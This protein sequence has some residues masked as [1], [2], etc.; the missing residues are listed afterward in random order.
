MTTRDDT[1]EPN[2][3]GGDFND[4]ESEVDIANINVNEGKNNLKLLNN[5]FV[6]SKADIQE[7]DELKSISAGVVKL[8]DWL[9]KLL[10]IEMT[11]GR[12][13]V[14]IFLCTDRDANI[15]LGSCSEY[16]PEDEEECDSDEHS[17]E[18]RMLG[19]VMV[20]GKHIVSIS[21]DKN[22]HL[23]DDHQMPLSENSDDVI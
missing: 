5:A 17:E 12:S 20:P 8:R 7:P 22:K 15:I 6:D 16:L 9:N 1:A 18:S 13:L 19:L 23:S 10:R 3:D 2:E 11:D 14:G 4:T 21:I